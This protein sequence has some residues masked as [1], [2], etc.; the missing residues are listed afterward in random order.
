M[1]FRQHAAMS[2][3]TDTPAALPQSPSVLGQAA[4]FGTTGPPFTLLY[5][6]RTA[7]DSSATTLAS[8]RFVL[9]AAALTMFGTSMRSGFAAPPQQ[10][11]SFVT[12]TRT[13][14][15][16]FLRDT[17]EVSSVTTDSFQVGSGAYG[18]DPLLPQQTPVTEGVH[19]M[20]PGVATT[21]ATERLL[22]STVAQK[23]FTHQRVSYL[24]GVGVA[25]IILAIVGHMMAG[26]A[27]PAPRDF[28]YRVPPAW[29]PENDTSYSFRAF[30][31]DVSLWIML[32]DLQPH[33]QCAAIITRLGGSARE[34]A[35]MISPQEIL[36]GGMRNGV[37]QD[38]VTYL[39]ATLQDRF[40]ALD[41][42]ARLASMTEMLAFSRRPGESINALLARYEIVRQ[43]AATEGQFVMSVEGCALQLLRACNIRPEQLMLLL[44]PYGGS[45]PTTDA[46]F[47]ILVTQLR[48]HGH[49]TEGVHGNIATVLRGPFHQARPG[50]YF[51]DGD[52]AYS[53]QEGTTLNATAREVYYGETPQP[54]QP[55]AAWAAGGRNTP[56]SGGPLGSPYSPMSYQDD[57]GAS[58]FPAI[59]MSDDSTDSETSSDNDSEE[60]PDPGVSQMSQAEAAEHIYMQYRKARRTWRRFTGKPVRKFRRHMNH[61][62]K[63]GKG[64]G[65]SK[66]KT[67]GFMWTHDDALTYL[68]GQ[69]KGNRSGSSGKGFGRR[70][71]PK[72]RA[73]NVMKCRVC[74]S[75]EHFAAK[76]PQGKGSGKGAGKSGFLNFTGAVTPVDEGN[77]PEVAGPSS[78]APPCAALGS[79]YVSSSFMASHEGDDTSNLMIERI[80]HQLGIGQP[81]PS[82]LVPSAA[83]PIGPPPAYP[84]VLA[85][86]PVWMRD[87]WIREAPPVRGIGSASSHEADRTPTDAW[88]R[89]NPSQLVPPNMQGIP[90]MPQQAP[91]RGI[92]IGPHGQRRHHHRVQDDDELSSANSQERQ[93]A[94]SPSPAPGPY[95]R[96]DEIGR[97]A[98]EALMR[99]PEPQWTGRELPKAASAVVQARGQQARNLSQLVASASL[100]ATL[101]TTQAAGTPRVGG[102]PPIPKY[103]Q[104]V[105]TLPM[106]SMGV[107]TAKAPP[108]LTYANTPTPPLDRLFQVRTALQLTA[109]VREENRANR[110]AQREETLLN[111]VAFGGPRGYT[112]ADAAPAQPTN[113]Q[114][115]N[116]PVFGPA[117]VQEPPQA[118]QHMDLVVYDGDEDTCSVCQT[119]FAAG[120]RV[121][122]LRC[123]HMFHTSCWEDLLNRAVPQLPRGRYP[124]R[125]LALR[126]PHSGHTAH[127][128][129]TSPERARGWRRGVPNRHARP[130]LAESHHR[131][132]WHSSLCHSLGHQ[133]LHVQ[134]VRGRRMAYARSLPRTDEAAGRPPVTHRGPWLRGKPVR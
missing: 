49:V 85:E 26:A 29:S 40:A 7:R 22:S 1:P 101:R 95:W 108:R 33:Q 45:M 55:W 76:C 37:L 133:H 42:E 94:R 121:C 126:G 66:G 99:Q 107:A 63:K 25:A 68:K 98:V 80:E 127:S 115:Q 4:P 116:I 130:P 110:Q 31:T 34:M 32:T 105:H 46:E 50:A 35:R 62:F 54:T 58:A 44:Q 6:L 117:P 67:R 125:S 65:K 3:F 129:R 14:P 86:D 104:Q 88:S 134:H 81:Q 17:Y 9:L 16:G 20:S 53:Q 47:N 103:M 118:D 72:D 89:W 102:P 69:G 96:P 23:I 28:N 75:D 84:P 124:H 39:L 113:P 132:N 93:R 52:V 12:Q 112:T 8:K 79:V 48:R 97:A 128:T 131:W 71:N 111:S 114:G 51:T 92:E 15:G 122:R 83:R 30:I 36:Q 90:V 11:P 61:H 56:D 78:D 38:P 106:V 21:S 5:R 41:E 123:R 74:D 91:R 10:V 24:T 109:Q 77:T 70:K 2:P 64:K 43:R 100:T 27:A 73:G 120:D 59:P 60:L 119:A 82:L 19:L 13:Q 87:P 18:S 57:Y